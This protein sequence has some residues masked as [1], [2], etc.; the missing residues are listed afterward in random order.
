MELGPNPG[1]PDVTAHTLSC[2]RLKVR[3]YLPFPTF[4]F[5]DSEKGTFLLETF[6][7]RQPGEGLHSS[8]SDPPGQL[9]APLSVTRHRE[10]ASAQP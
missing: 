4:S 3:G 2:F 6:L 1:M 9:R 7:R 5:Q 10:V 8:F